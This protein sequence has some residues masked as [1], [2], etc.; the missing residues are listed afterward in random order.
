M[1]L[2]KRKREPVPNEMTAQKIAGAIVG[3][4]KRIARYL[5]SKTGKL[6]TKTLLTALVIFCTAFGGYCL[7]LLI[8]ALS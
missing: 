6:S 2:F 5:N 3:R 4:Q 1:S 7:Y 8:R